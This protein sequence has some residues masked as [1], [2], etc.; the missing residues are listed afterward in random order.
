MGAD[1]ITRYTSR[2]PARTVGQYIT[3]FGRAETYLKQHN[4]SY[5]TVVAAVLVRSPLLTVEVIVQSYDSRPGT[6]G[7]LPP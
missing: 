5:A 7:T 6:K 3:K 1:E 4:L 2:S